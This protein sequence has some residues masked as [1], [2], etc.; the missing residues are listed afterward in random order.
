MSDSNRQCCKYSESE[1]HTKTNILVTSSKETA[2]NC[3]L[4]TCS[5]IQ[6]IISSKYSK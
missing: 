5:L 6:R 2:N 1:I 3:F 4:R